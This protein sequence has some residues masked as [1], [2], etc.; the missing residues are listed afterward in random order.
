MAG[1]ADG[2]TRHSSIGPAGQYDSCAV[3]LADDQY[4]RLFFGRKLPH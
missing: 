2:Q 4:A 3:L 1:L